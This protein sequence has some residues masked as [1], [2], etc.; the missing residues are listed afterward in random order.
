MKGMNNCL[1]T[2]NIQQPTSNAQ[3]FRARSDWMLVVEC[4]LLDVWFPIA[5]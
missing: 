4:W 1:K 2:T 5:Q 3:W